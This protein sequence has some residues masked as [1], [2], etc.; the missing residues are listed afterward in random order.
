LVLA[1]A[2]ALGLT[3]LSA[4]RQG[5]FTPTAYLYVELPGA[6]GMQVGTPVKLKG[7]KIGEVDDVALE[8]DL[9]VKVRLRVVLERLPLLAAD[10]S[11][12][13]GREGPIG[14]KF[15]ELD[16]GTRS[17]ARLKPEATLRMD[18]GTELD[19]VMATVKVAVEKL[20]SAIGKVEPILDDTKKLTGAASAVSTDV[21]TTLSTLLHNMETI[22]V[23]LKKVGDTATQVVSHADADR[24]H[25][26]ADLRKTLAAA[27]LATETAHAAL[28]TVD[29]TLASDLPALVSKVQRSASDVNAITA[30]ARQQVPPALRAGRDVV[31]DSADITAG[32]KRT[33]PVSALVGPPPEGNLPLDGS[34]G[35]AK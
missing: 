18:T 10:A 30:E 11:A 16:P 17:Q 24:A 28:K 6:S 31:Q 1:M 13:F 27:T 19:D 23:Q 3:G 26:V 33:W 22:S 25:V 32:V 7:F 20:A 2:A 35:A 14:G 9:N 12:H 4:W 21:R 15:I 8:P 5:W 29:T 34:E